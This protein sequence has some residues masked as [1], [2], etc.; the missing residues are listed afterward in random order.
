MMKVA[1]GSAWVAAMTGILCAA[2]VAQQKPP[3]AA[4][5]QKQQ[6]EQSAAPPAADAPAAKPP[7]PGPIETDPAKMS[8]PAKTPASTNAD[9]SYTIGPEDVLGIAVW[10]E[11]RLTGPVM[12]RPDGR[13]SMAL[14]GEITASGLTPTQL[15]GAIG[16]LLMKNDL[17]KK[18]QVTVQVNQINSKKYYI[19]GEVLKPGPNPLVVPTHV[20]E[21]LVN[22]GGFKDFANVKKIE[23]IRATGE[24][25]KFNYK[26]VIHGKHTEQN[27]LL[28]PGDIIIVP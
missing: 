18:P 16:D 22:A 9:P 21:A 3:D 8:G 7:A 12:V 27:I 4:P 14:I 11:P 1:I 15:E 23:I 24:R 28:K 17:I 2:A 26:D 6:R 5:E 13:I 10:N 25:F 19:Q 20:L